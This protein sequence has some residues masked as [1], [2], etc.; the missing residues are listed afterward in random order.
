[1]IRDRDSK[2]AAGFDAVFVG[3]DTRIVR[4]PVRHPERAGRKGTAS[5]HA[6]RLL[7]AMARSASGEGAAQR[8]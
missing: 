4:T 7:A 3:A 8:P 6:E 5:D 2:F 1:L